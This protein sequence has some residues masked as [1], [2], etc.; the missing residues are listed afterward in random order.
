MRLRPFVPDDLPRVL[1]LRR[2]AFAHTAQPSPEAAERYWRTVLLENPWP[3]LRVPSLICEDDGGALLG[4]LG[5]VSHPMRWRG[6]DIVAATPTQLMADPRGSGIVGIRLLKE[7]M[8][9]RHDLAFSDAANETARRLWEGLGGWTGHLASLTWSRPLRAAR[10]GMQAWGSH[11]LARAFR[12][13]LSPAAAVA[14]AV[15]SGAF[16]MPGGYSAR[17]LTPGDVIDTLAAATAKVALVPRYDEASFAWLLQRAGERA[18]PGDTRAELVMHESGPAGWFI[19]QAR[20]SRAEVVQLAGA[21]PHRLAVLQTL[22]HRVAA[23]GLTV[24]HGRYDPLFADAFAAESCV[25]SR[26]GAWALV[27]SRDPDIGRAALGGDAFLS[28]LEGEWW[29]NF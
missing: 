13:G 20:G 10:Y 26:S 9:G 11:P 24:V 19:W 3:D 6:R 28:R 17:P 18:A 16:V 27:Q 5:I 7:F 8:A 1:E 23:A 22:L 21:P 2:A 14:D 12:L 15:T 29:M 25:M 4:F